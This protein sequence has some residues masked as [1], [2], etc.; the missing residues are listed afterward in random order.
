M[1]STSSGREVYAIGKDAWGNREVVVVE[2]GVTH[3]LP[4]AAEY[5]YEDTEAQFPYSLPA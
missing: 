4:A 5:T 1:S 3:D 2:D